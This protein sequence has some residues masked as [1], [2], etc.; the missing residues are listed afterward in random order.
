MNLETIKKELKE[1]TKVNV[2]P[3]TMQPDLT[4]ELVNKMEA[5]LKAIK[6]ELIRH[7]SDPNTDQG[8]YKDLE[9]EYQES[10]MKLCSYAMLLGVNPPG[11]FNDLKL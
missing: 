10:R 8:E 1:I 7:K 4:E 11:R 2:D 6:E 3:K 9:R 5:K